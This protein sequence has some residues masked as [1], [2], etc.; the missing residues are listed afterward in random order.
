M[1][2][3][4][5]AGCLERQRRIDQLLDENRRLKAQLRYRDRQAQA[6]FFGSSTPSAQRPVKANSPP[7]SQGKPG[8]ARSG[9]PGHGRAAVAATTA[10]RVI[11]VPVAPRCPGCGGRL[12]AQGV[13][14]RSV[15]D[16]APPQPAPLLYRLHRGYCPRCHRTVQAPLP[17]VLPKALFGNE[18]TAQLVWL[19]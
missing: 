8:G 10:A 7:A 19:H 18:L 5:C 9:H 3:A 4:F 13:R 11:E 12:E 17:A 1:R 6:G 14:S 15:V 2:R 16:I